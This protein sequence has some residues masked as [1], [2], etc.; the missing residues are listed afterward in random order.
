MNSPH[1]TFEVLLL[2]VSPQE[3]STFVPSLTSRVQ[4]RLEVAPKFMDFFPLPVTLDAFERLDPVPLV[5]FCH[6]L[7]EVCGF[8]EEAS[9]GLA[10]VAG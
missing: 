2:R 1:V 10:I 9:T 5:L 7:A 4:P 6:M 8:E 3:L